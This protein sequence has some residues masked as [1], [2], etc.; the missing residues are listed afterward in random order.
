MYI[1]AESKAWWEVVNKDHDESPKN[2]STEE[3]Q[4][5]LC[6]TGIEK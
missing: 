2:Y 3:S 4:L 6:A 5:F 1:P